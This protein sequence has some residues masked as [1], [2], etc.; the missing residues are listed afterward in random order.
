MMDA[1]GHNSALYS[2]TGP[3]TIWD[4]EMNFVMKHAPNAKWI[5]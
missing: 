2:Y 4:I 3:G 5:A 1:L